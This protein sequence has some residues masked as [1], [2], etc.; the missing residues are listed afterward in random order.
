MASIKKL[1][2]GGY[3][4]PVAFWLFYILGICIAFL[5]VVVIVLAAI[6]VGRFD[7]G[8]VIASVPVWTCWIVSVVGVWRSAAPYIAANGAKAFWG[9]AARILAALLTARGLYGLIFEGVSES[10]L[11]IVRG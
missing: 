4:L 5:L 1:W 11:V 7:L 8:V 2:S 3:S 6:Q 9:W 10:L